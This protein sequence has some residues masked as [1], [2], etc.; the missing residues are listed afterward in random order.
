M[1]G[2]MPNVRVAW[3][4][5]ANMAARRTILKKVGVFDP[6]LGPGS[7]FKAGE[8]VDLALRVLAAG[9]RIANTPEV[10]VHHLGVRRGDEAS[11]LMRG[12][13]FATGAVYCK[14]LRLGT[15]GSMRLLA[16]TVLM[17]V[18]NTARN[19][20]RGTRPTGL[21][22]LIALSQGIFASLGREVDSDRG[23]YRL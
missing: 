9:G 10:T 14:H 19:L 13:L 18:E 1:Q 15:R 17:H 6:L 3:G 20:L 11:Q 7:K 5:G 22:Q 8:E 23:V 2:R 16:E 12:Y 21:G 4:I